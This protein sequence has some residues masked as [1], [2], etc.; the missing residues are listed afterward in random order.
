MKFIDSKIHGIL[1]YLVVLFLAI[2]PVVF[3]LPENT[4]IFTYCLG[5]IHLLLTIATRFELGIIKI[6]PFSIHGWIELAVSIALVACAFYFG[7]IE[8]ANARTFY[9]LVAGAIFLVWLFTNYHSYPKSDRKSSV[10][11]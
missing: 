4:A 3:D 11:A 2:S 10:S 9:L 1:D 7:S 5:A 8:G 6:I